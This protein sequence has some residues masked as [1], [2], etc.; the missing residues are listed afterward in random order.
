MVFIQT[1]LMI[2]FCRLC[3]NY[4]EL[5]TNRCGNL[6]Y[7]CNS[8]LDS[9]TA[10]LSQ[11]YDEVMA[12]CNEVAAHINEVIGHFNEVGAHNDE[13]IRRVLLL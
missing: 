6:V 3:S 11:C 4:S 9:Q 7:Q 1:P 13:V 10:R 5:W 2:A 12:N 8:R